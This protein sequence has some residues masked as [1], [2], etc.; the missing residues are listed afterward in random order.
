MPSFPRRGAHSNRQA[1]L[2]L[3]C[4]L[5]N[6]ST[7]EWFFPF[8]IRTDLNLCP[9]QNLSAAARNPNGVGRRPS[10]SAQG[11]GIHQL[12]N[13][14]TVGRACVRHDAPLVGSEK[15]KHSTV[16]RE[17]SRHHVLV[18]D[19]PTALTIAK[20]DP[21]PGLTWNVSPNAPIR[22]T[23]GGAIQW[24]FGQLRYQPPIEAAPIDDRAFTEKLGHYDV[25]TASGCSTDVSAG[26]D[27]ASGVDTARI[28]TTFSVLT[29]TSA[30]PELT[31]TG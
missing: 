13:L 4:H 24:P 19:S 12:S 27:S 3:A 10:W 18:D 31:G 23:G 15:N 22:G 17:P 11:L 5:C 26:A 20:H 9:H 21:L 25:G 1:T 8:A 7:Q 29:L 16:R 6:R 2:D 30:I 14:G 28:S